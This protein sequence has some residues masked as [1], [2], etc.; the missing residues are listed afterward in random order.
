MNDC[1][2]KTSCLTRQEY[3][4]TWVRKTTN[5]LS[6]WSADCNGIDLFLTPSGH[7]FEE[8]ANL[9]KQELRE[10]S[11]YNVIIEAIASGASRLNEI[12]TKCK[13]ESN[14]C[15]KYLSSL[16]TLGLIS[17]EYSYSEKAGKRSIYKLE[18]FLL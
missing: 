2:I 5:V 15:A 1:L 6:L 18:D 8:P 11:T 17:K 7:F 10:L 4:N 9:I 3:E 14:K 12:S 16:I 13:L